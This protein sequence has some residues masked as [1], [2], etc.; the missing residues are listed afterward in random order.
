MGADRHKSTF[1]IDTHNAAVFFIIHLFDFQ[2]VRLCRM[3][4]E[5]QEKQTKKELLKI[6]NNFIIAQAHQ[7]VPFQAFLQWTDSEESTV[8][9]I[10]CSSI[11]WEKTVEEKYEMGINKHGKKN[12]NCRKD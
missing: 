8:G 9:K 7:V 3:K 1:A 11:L 4:D 10:L 12:I 6:R 2:A 5:K